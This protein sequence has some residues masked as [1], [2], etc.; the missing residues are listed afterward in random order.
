MVAH[1]A[2]QRE[3]RFYGHMGS[4]DLNTRAVKLED[5]VYAGSVCYYWSAELQT[6]NCVSLKK[7]QR[8]FCWAE[9]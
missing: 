8:I 1:I 6:A 2:A 7:R 3:K 5:I 4:K 9:S